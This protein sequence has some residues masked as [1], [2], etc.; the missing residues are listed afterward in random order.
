MTNP[1]FTNPYEDCETLGETSKLNSIIP[2]DE[3]M[4]LKSIRPEKYTITTTINL[5]IS[6]L[7]H[8]CKQRGI[9]THADR[10]AFE[11][12][13]GECS[14]HGPRDCES[15]ITQPATGIQRITV[16]RPT[17]EVTT[18]YDPGRTDNVRDRNTNKT[19]LRPNV[20]GGSATSKRRTTNVVKG[21]TSK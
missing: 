5:L 14:L 3:L 15:R 2:K 18:S 4:F 17:P 11:A 8:E 13:V 7:I 1:L 6:K 16:A 9:V 19:N 21:K 10:D 12:F 20:L